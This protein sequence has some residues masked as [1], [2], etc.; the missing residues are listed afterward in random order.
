MDYVKV[1]P[2]VPDPQVCFPPCLEFFVDM[3]SAYENDT[4]TLDVEEVS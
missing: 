3:I 4:N 2:A 1:F